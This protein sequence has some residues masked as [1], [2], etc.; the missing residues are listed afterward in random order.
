M[1]VSVLTKYQMWQDIKLISKHR[2]SVSLQRQNRMFSSWVMKQDLLLKR[3]KLTFSKWLPD[4]LLSSN[5]QANSLAGC[6][7]QDSTGTGP[8]PPN[9]WKQQV[10][11]NSNCLICSQS[12]QNPFKSLN[13]TGHSSTTH[14]HHHRGYQKVIGGSDIKTIQHPEDDYLQLCS[15]QDTET[16]SIM[17]CYYALKNIWHSV[18]WSFY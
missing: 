14:I 16:Y 7:Q 3:Q 9:Q 18:T 1:V 12:M 8:Q 17:W 4:L 13:P 10:W 2:L 11:H 5:H 15:L 6:L